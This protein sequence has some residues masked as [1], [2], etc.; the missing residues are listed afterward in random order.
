MSVQRFV[1]LATV[2]AALMFTTACAS[3]ISRTHQP[4]EMSSDVQGTTVTATEMGTGRVFGPWQTPAWI[5]LDKNHTYQVEFN[6]PDGDKLG[7]EPP[8]TFDPISLLNILGLL[9][10]IGDL[11]T[12]AIQKYTADGYFANFGEKRVEPSI[13]GSKSDWKA[14]E[15]Q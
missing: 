10:F 12:G 15:N 13:P 1:L 8:R 9:G 6:T 11:F 7:F 3:I 14:G 2:V 5:T 4:V